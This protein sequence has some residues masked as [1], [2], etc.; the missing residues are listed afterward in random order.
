MMFELLAEKVKSHQIDTQSPMI[1][2]FRFE[3]AE[4]GA[5]L[6]WLKAQHLFPQ[7]YLNFRDSDNKIAAL[8]K[9]RS[10]GDEISAQQFIEQTQQPLIG[11]LTFDK[12]G[13]FWLPRLLIE[14]QKD[15][16]MISV[17]VDNQADLAQEKQQ[18]L[19]AIQ[20]L[21]HFAELEP[22]NSQARL[23]S[24]KANQEE[25]CHW[26]EQALRAIEQGEL[27]KVVLANE[28]LFESAQPINA[29]DFLAESEKQNTGCYHFLYAE[30]PESTFVGSTPERL[31]ERRGV[32]V[33]TEALAGTALMSDDV[34]QNQAQADWLLHDQ[35][36]DDENWLVVKDISD[37]LQEFVSHIQVGDVELKQLRRVQHLRR[38]IQ[39]ELKSSFADAACLHAIHPTAAVS[40]LPQQNALAFLQ[41]TE[42][43]DRT[44]YAGTLGMMTQSHGEFCV[45]IRCAFIEQNNIRIFAGA[46]IVAGSIPLLEWQ[47]IERKAS[48]L[49]TLLGTGK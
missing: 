6:A 17:F 11:G 33:K 22:L 26:V 15:Q 8:G 40:G 32:Q 46:G 5:L 35:K 48:G 27:N 42:N 21:T 16:V 28:S 38:C 49:V 20:T 34:Q 10:F 36:N 37:N 9:V 3:M 4:F 45:T 47:E 30:T 39:A 24:Q 44:W 7:Y 41:K 13:H 25:W 31:F 14:Q 18:A 29:K 12:K 19:S 1:T 43:F 23:V 2:A